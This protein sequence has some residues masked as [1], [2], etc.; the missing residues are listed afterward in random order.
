MIKINLVTNEKLFLKEDSFYCN[1]IEIKN[2]TDEL[3]KITETKLFGR[4][5]KNNKFHKIICK[6]VL[7]KNDIFSYLFSIYKE[8]NLKNSI[9]LVVSLTP[10]TFLSVI[11]LKILKKNFL[12]YLRSDGFKEY[13]KIVGFIGPLI[14]KL[15]F[16]LA[17]KNATL[18]ASGKHILRDRVGETVV[19]SSLNK[20]WS[21]N[22]K[23]AE[24]K[25]IKALYVGR[26]RIEKGVYSLINL[27]KKINKDMSL[28][29]IG[30]D[31]K[32]KE[33]N[34]NKR[35]FYKGIISDELELIKNYDDHNIFILPSFTEAYSMVIDEAL[36]R[37][38]PVII[39]ED[40]K[41]I[42]GDRKGIFVCKRD[43][44][45]LL[46]KINY[47]SMNYD[48]ILSEIKKNQFTNKKEFAQKIYKKLSDL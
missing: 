25:Y 21:L 15:F 47:I 23:P 8:A 14:Y 33:I 28:T 42:I 29:I 38:R 12:I 36:S 7:N 18:I 44:K 2:L 20:N 35:I 17:T 27:F 10:Y 30:D 24:F 39:F 13:K 34:D 48:D 40:I 43:E 9:F 3:N 37:L 46:S 26:V 41:N 16:S 22:L 45:D 4:L 31:E 1:N 6:T 11:L 5:T 19:P 32:N